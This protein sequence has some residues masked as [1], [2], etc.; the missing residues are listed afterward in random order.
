MWS[1]EAYEI[2][3]CEEANVSEIEP[4]QETLTVCSVLNLVGKMLLRWEST[5]RKACSELHWIDWLRCSRVCNEVLEWLWSHGWEQGLRGHRSLGSYPAMVPGFSFIRSFYCKMSLIIV[6][7]LQISG[8][9][10]RVNIF[11]CLGTVPNGSYNYDVCLRCG[12][13]GFTSVCPVPLAGWGFPC[14]YFSARS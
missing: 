14:D 8:K 5:E 12:A 1:S 11:K 6:P 3:R 13:A 10:G 9:P 7:T 2:I 4:R